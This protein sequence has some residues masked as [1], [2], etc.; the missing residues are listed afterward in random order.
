MKYND[1]RRQT[2]KIAVGNLT[3][4]GDSPITVQSMTNTDTHDVSATL[5]Q[6]RAL[7]AAGCDIVRLT[8]PTLDA[9][10]TIRKIKESGMNI[11]GFF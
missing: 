2:R 9:C 5:A 11:P 3:I 4:G 8:V 10:K 7:E 1:F 6:I